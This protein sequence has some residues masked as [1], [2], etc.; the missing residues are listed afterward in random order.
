MNKYF[1]IAFVVGYLIGGLNAYI[2]LTTHV[3]HISQPAKMV[4]ADN[5]TLW[6]LCPDGKTAAEEI[7]ADGSK[8][9][10]LPCD[11]ADLKL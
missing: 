9:I 8:I 6:K 3:N 1:Y 4:P 11:R 7:S 5:Y 2:W 10:V